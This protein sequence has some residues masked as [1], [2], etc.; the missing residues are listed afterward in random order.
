MWLSGKVAD[1]F[2]RG[3]KQHPHSHRRGVDH[4]PEDASPGYS[5]TIERASLP[6]ELYARIAPDL[7]D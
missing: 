3:P 2:L 1:E 4:E 7:D 6:T 5:R